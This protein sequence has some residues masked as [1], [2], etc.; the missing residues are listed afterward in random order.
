MDLND[1]QIDLINALALEPP[2]ARGR[3]SREE[4][5]ADAFFQREERRRAQRR[6]AEEKA[7][8]YRLVSVELARR[9]ISADVRRHILELAG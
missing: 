2:R 6:A 9:N 3:P 8:A 5:V 1:D 7:R 4:G